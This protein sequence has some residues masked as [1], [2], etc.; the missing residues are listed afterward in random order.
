MKLAK[1]T[2]FLLLGAFIC[3]CTNAPK[4][5][6]EMSGSSDQRP[7]SLM[8]RKVCSPLSF[9]AKKNKNYLIRD[10]IDLEVTDDQNLRFYFLNDD[11]DQSG[12]GKEWLVVLNQECQEVFNSSLE[13]NSKSGLVGN[14]ESEML[15]F[16]LSSRQRS[17]LCLG[18]SGC[19]SGI[20]YTYYDV[21]YKKGKLS[22]KELI[23]SSTGWSAVNFL[24]E[25]NI[26]LLAEQETTYDADGNIMNC[27]YDCPSIVKVSAF[28]LSTDRFLGNYVSKKEHYNLT[29]ENEKEY[30]EWLEKFN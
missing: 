24:P 5:E 6:H 11:P 9:I 8:S 28:N 4:E 30:S 22:F 1:Y 18:Y 29:I 7:S 19:G 3:S 15:R 10:S 25:K 21:L 16:K 14:V 27:H 2:S 13:P 20:T 12:C 17:I 23:S 26:Y